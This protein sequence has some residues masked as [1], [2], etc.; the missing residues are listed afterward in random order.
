MN[1]SGNSVQ[2]WTPFILVFGGSDNQSIFPKPFWEG[3]IAPA[4]PQP[5]WEPQFPQSLWERYT[6]TNHAAGGGQFHH[7]KIISTVFIFLSGAL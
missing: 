4:F 6:L 7:E 2:C 1:L 3:L 5:L